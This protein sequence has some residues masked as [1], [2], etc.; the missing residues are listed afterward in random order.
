M[1][2]NYFLTIKNLKTGQSIG[3]PLNDLNDLYSGK[4]FSENKIWA[5]G[6]KSLM[7]LDLDIENDSATKTSPEQ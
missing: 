4:L 6:F 5:T 1:E 2:A 3:T 7:N